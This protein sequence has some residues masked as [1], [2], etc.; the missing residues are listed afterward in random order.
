MIV[1]AVCLVAVAVAA[2][3]LR[4]SAHRLEAVASTVTS[5]AAWQATVELAAEDTREL[6]AAVDG[7]VGR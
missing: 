1:A 3:C 7:R 6:A 4:R 5:T 2:W